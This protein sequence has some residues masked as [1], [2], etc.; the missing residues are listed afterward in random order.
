M[1]MIYNRDV[2][3]QKMKEAPKYDI[4]DSHLHFL[5]FTQDSDGFPALT[6]SMDACGVSE[7][8]IFGMPIV[9]K[10]DHFMRKKPLYYMSDDSRCY[11][12]SGTDHILAHELMEQSE[13][14]RRRFHPF[15]CG[16]DCTDK[17]AADQIERGEWREGV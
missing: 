6:K 5:D 14:V 13:E 17:Y 4:V 11:Y 8:V 9:K 10:W 2:E 1:K 3:I 12:Y 7:A 16:V 15:C